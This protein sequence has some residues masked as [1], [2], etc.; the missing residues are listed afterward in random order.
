MDIRDMDNVVIRAGERVGIRHLRETDR[1]AY[2]ALRVNSR[3][4][5]EPWEPIPPSGMDVYSPEVFDRDFSMTDT[6]REQ[7]FAIVR[8]SDGELLGRVALGCIERGVF[9]NG[10]FGYW[11]GADH[12]GQ[13]YMTEALT[14]CVAHAFAPI[15]DGGLG[16]HRVCAN[17]LPRNVASRK[18]LERVGF[19]KEGYSE[20]YLQIGG[21][22]EDHERWGMTV[23]RWGDDERAG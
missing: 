11:I 8:L 23:E 9:L 21:G 15:E 22:W 14:L 20:K 18:L 4:H 16:L 3:A 13:G 5:L 1:D 12:A 2:T 10:R 6:E 17:I 19:V 7:R